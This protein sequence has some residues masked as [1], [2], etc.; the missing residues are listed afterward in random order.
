MV[1]GAIQKCGFDVAEF[2]LPFMS[3]FAFRAYKGR[4]KKTRSPR[5]L[6][7]SPDARVRARIVDTERGALELR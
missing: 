4:K 1:A 7:G 5:F 2:G 6:M 3:C